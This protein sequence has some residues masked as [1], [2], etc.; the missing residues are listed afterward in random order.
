MRLADMT[1]IVTGATRGLG[2]AI[3]KA[4]VAEGALVVMTGRS[5]AEGQRAAEALG[6]NASFVA[7]DLENR[8]QL[9][10]LVDQADARFGRVDILVNNAGGLHR[11]NILDLPIEDYERV[12][13]LN[14]TAPLLLT[15]RVGRIMVRERKGGSIINVTSTGAAVC[16]PGGTPY[17]VSKAGLAMLTRITALDLG[18]Y[19]IRANAIGPGTFATELMLSSTATTPGL[20]DALLETTP[21]G[22]FGELDELAAV[23]VF[24]A[25][26]DSSYVSGQS[27]YVDGGRL[28]LNPSLT[29]PHRADWLDFRR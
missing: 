15:Q 6:P 23:A 13:A 8:A 20:R 2:L 28:V 7:C 10:A 3:A 12:L 14:L 11:D 29:A 4:F 18:Q 9:C 27:L 17:H 24:F 26:R 19:G 21:L 25:S 22:R 1:A 5:A 16:R